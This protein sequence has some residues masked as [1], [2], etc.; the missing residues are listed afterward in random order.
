MHS[1]NLKINLIT[2]FTISNADFVKI[3][4]KISSN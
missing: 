4:F 1:F 3:L 2:S